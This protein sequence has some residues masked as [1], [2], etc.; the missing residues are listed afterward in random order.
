MNKHALVF[1]GLLAISGITVACDK[2]APPSLPDPTSA[3]TA[4]MVKAKNDMK[5]YID[6]AEAYLK[7]V[8]ADAAKYNDMVD[9][10]QKAADDFNGIV[11]KYKNRMGAS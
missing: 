9:T 2:P 11:R 10:M 5:S 4:Q 3:V 8:E 6:Q 1:T 7:C